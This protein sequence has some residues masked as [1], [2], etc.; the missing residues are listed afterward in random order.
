MFL[1]IQKTL[2]CLSMFVLRRTT[3]I[4]VTGATGNVG[5]ELVRAL[6]SAGHEVRAL[7]RSTHQ[8]MLPEGVEEIQGDLN[9]PKTLSAALA[10]V[11]GVFLLSGYQDMPEFLAQVRRA[12][13][14]RVV[15]LSS[16]CVVGG[17]MSNAIARY[18]LLS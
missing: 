4:L 9:Q 3:M 15:L 17:S 18:N 11:Q 2:T 14:E 8:N 12:G 1:I 16:G 13:V 6:I 10:G 5:G 7:V